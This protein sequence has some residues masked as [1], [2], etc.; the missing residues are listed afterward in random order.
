MDGFFSV[1]FSALQISDTDEGALIEYGTSSILINR[2]AA[3][4]LSQD[5][6][7]I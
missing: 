2:I 6:F 7:I 3:A 5:D 4:D 1:D